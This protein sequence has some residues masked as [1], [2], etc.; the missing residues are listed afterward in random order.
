MIALAYTLSLVCFILNVSLF[1]RLQW[2]HGGAILWICNVITGSLSPFLGVLGALGAG[3][4]WIYR[5]P[6]AFVAGL[7]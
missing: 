1:F 3:L 6:V 4:G 5:A 2:P 7:T